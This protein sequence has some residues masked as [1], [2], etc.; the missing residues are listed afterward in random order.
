MP[1]TKAMRHTNNSIKLQAHLK[2]TSQFELIKMKKLTIFLITV[3]GWTMTY[4][5]NIPNT[6]EDSMRKII[7]DGIAAYNNQDWA[8]VKKGL[9]DNVKVYEFPNAIR[10]SSADE[11]ISHYPKTFAKYPNNKAEIIDITVIGNKV[12]LK[13]KITGR[14][15]LFYALNIYEIANNKIVN[16]WFISNSPTTPRP[17]N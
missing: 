6:S 11:L 5:Q 2:G 8:G 7:T 17:K 13:Q 3:L 16:I 15:D 9:A 14:G 4:C 12:I 1:H 10:D